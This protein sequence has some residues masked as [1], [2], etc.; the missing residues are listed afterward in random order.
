MDLFYTNFEKDDKF[1]TIN[2]IDSKHITRSFRKSTGDL[3]KITNGN[4]SICDAEIIKIGINIKV[5]IKKIVSYEREKTS[6]H[7]A[8]S[9]LKNTSRFEWFVEKATELG[10]NQIT[11]IISEYSEKK[12]VNTER[13]ERII[14]S[15]M[16]QSNQCYRP[17][18]N[19]IVD[20]KTFILSNKEEKI[21]ANLKNK[22][23][24]QKKL[25]KSNN[26]CLLIGPE[27][28]FSDK[29]I[30]YSI[31]NNVKEITLGNNRLRSETAAIY[32]ISAIKAIVS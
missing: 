3:I 4:G 20:Y 2:Q 23:K 5:K 21:M 10:I 8:L 13:L 27:G 6:I 14:I 17:I 16:K 15:S 9:P 11:P 22:N 19:T 29:E 31:K 26:L 32:S 25:L 1:I 24:L 30:E 12:K 7:V 18:L 28:G